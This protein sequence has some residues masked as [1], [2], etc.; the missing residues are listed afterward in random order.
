MVALFYCSAKIQGRDNT[1]FF[2]S[3]GDFKPF[4]SLLLAEPDDGFNFKCSGRG[5]GATKNEKD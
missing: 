4:R 3:N 2:E 1:V 5:D